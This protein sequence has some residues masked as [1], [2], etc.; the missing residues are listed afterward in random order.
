MP[1][2][3][4]VFIEGGIYHVYCRTSRGEAVFAD[5]AEAAEFTGIVQ[6][7]KERDGFA[8]FA[9]AVMSNHYHIALRTG[10]APLWRS[11]ASIQVLT[12]K[13][14]NRRHRLYGPLWQGRYKAR[15]VHNDDYLYQLLAYIHL[16]PVSAGLVDDP[17][18]YRWSGHLEII[19]KDDPGLTD[20]NAVLSLFGTHRRAAR[21]A[22]VKML[23]A[24]GSTTWIGEDLPKL[25]WWQTERDEPVASPED[26]AY[27]DYLGR[28]IAPE[29]PLLPVNTFLERACG[30][31]DVDVDELA[32]RRRG[33]RLRDLREMVVAVGVEKFRQRVREIAETLQKNPGSVSRWV[34]KAAERRFS[35]RDFA[36]RLSC[37]EEAL[38]VKD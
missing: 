31:L 15:H 16:N 25:P 35:D 23:N 13:G 8:I 27:V 4:R 21:R 19:G 24:A 38:Q 33:P 10:K 34:T 18:K 1:R 22:Y 7:V 26:G 14:F 5:E 28:S 6:R 20:C 32:S 29:R 17:A 11:M 12:T 3:P 30:V 2:K 9:W 37:L 36:K